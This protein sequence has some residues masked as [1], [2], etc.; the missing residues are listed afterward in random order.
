VACHRE[1]QFNKMDKKGT[2]L[3]GMRPT[4]K[5]H[6]GNLIGALNNWVKLQDEYHCCYMVADWHALTSE[7]ADTKDIETNIKEMVIDWLSVGLDPEK[8]ILFQQ[9]KVLQHS[10]LHLLLSMLTPLGWLERCPT[11]KEQQEEIKDKDLATYGFLGY[12]VLQAADIMVYRANAVPV[13]Q[14]QVPHLE[15]T[16]EIARR[17]NYLYGKACLPTGK[18]FPEPE[19]LLTSIPKLAGTDGRKMSKSYNNCIYL[20]DEQDIIIK[21]VR[22][23]ITDPKKIKLGDPGNPDICTVY[24]YHLTFN[25][26]ETENISKKC[27]DGSLGCTDC[28]K[29]LADK[30]VLFLEGFQK[31]RKEII[32]DKDCV[33][34][35]LNKGNER[36]REKAEQTMVEVRKAIWH[37]K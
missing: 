34:K 1:L 27:K 21:K 17:F 7:Y 24:S 3:S 8:S 5:L 28:K 30:I 32:K 16:R 31:K 4:G 15:I 25:K 12:P 29:N 9:S 35:V 14:D 13:G 23:M 33:E 11:Y 36:A 37:T 6:L 19:P 22:A 10:E 20:S 2:I 26:N 18:I